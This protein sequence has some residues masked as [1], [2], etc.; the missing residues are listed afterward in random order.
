MWQ[1]NYCGTVKTFITKKMWKFSNN[2]SGPSYILADKNLFWPLS[3]K[4]SLSK[5]MLFHRFIIRSCIN[6]LSAIESCN[7]FQLFMT[8]R[9]WTK[10]VSK[11]WKIFPRWAQ[12]VL[13]VFTRCAPG[14]LSPGVTEVCIYS[15]PNH[16]SGLCGCSKF[17]CMMLQKL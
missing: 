12:T 16:L 3:C 4:V 1:R 14:D 6:M 8:M 5:Y 10:I 9:N 15:K 7:I 17:S 13:Q 2:L 11:K